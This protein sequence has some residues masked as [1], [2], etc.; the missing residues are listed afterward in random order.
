MFLC[1]E[2]IA[3]VLVGPS[4]SCLEETMR[5]N[6]DLEAQIDTGLLSI[7]YGGGISIAI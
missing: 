1:A 2:C 4:S 6:S 5:L 3:E 7:D